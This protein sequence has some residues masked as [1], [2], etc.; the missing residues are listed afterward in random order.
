MQ[1]G[2]LDFNFGV[3][4]GVFKLDEHH[5][6]RKRM[7]KVNETKAVD[8]VGILDEQELYLIEVKDFR[9]HRIETGE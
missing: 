4:W 6:Y 5:D 8:F 2:F 7:E 9:Q 1:E 3:R